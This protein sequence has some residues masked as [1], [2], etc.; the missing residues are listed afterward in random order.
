VTPNIP[1]PFFF[2]VGGG[3]TVNAASEQKGPF[4]V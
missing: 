1:P 4:H 2:L 3:C